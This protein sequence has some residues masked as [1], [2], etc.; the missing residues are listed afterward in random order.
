MSMFQLYKGV[1]PI[2]LSCSFK[3]YQ[4]LIVDIDTGADG[5]IPGDGDHH[6]Q[7]HLEDGGEGKEEG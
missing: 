1:R 2:T 6:G 3:Y 4:L 5:P 7:V